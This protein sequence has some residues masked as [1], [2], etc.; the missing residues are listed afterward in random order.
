MQIAMIQD[1]ILPLEKLKPAYLDRG[2]YFGDGV[3]EVLRSYNGKI[4]ALE[5]HL[6]RFGKSLSEIGINGLSIENVRSK[7]LTAFEKAVIKDAKIYFHITRGSGLRSHNCRESLQP[8][9]FLTVTELD[10]NMQK[11]T[12]GIAVSTHPDLRWKRVDIKS[13]NLLPNVLAKRAAAERGCDEAIFVDDDGF[14]TEGAGSTFF[15]IFSDCL[16]TAPLSANILPSVTRKYVVKAAENV[17]LK[18]K[19]Q[20]LASQEVLNA[21]ELFTS[22]TTD[23]IIPVVKID[24]QPVGD[25]K[26]GRYTKLL[27]AEFT[28]FTQ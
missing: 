10:D 14:I 15:A 6:R 19:E 23:G 3:Y 24:G 9:F 4:F 7:V 26:P 8:N 20:S 16:Q 22:A 5:D 12:K 13:L 18:V 28:K 25:G 2:L 21:N 11:K 1:E 17:G 27:M